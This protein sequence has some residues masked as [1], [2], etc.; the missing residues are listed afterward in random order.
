MDFTSLPVQRSWNMDFIHGALSFAVHTEEVLGFHPFL[1]FRKLTSEKE[2][3]FLK[4]FW[5]VAFQCSFSNASSQTEPGGLCSGE[6]SLENLPESVFEMSMTG[7]SYSIYNAVH[8]IAEG[9]HAMHSTSM[10]RTIRDKGWHETVYREPWQLLHYLRSISFNNNVGETISFESNGKLIA[11]FDIINWVTFPNQSFFR[12]KVGR[13][14]SQHFPGKIFTISEDTIQWPR[15]LTEGRP[16]SVCNANC[17]SGYSRTKIEGKPFCCYDCHPCPEGKISNLNDMDDC[18]P[19]PEDQYPNKEQNSCLSKTL[20]FLSYEETLGSILAICSLSSSIILL[21]VLGIFIKYKDTPIVKANNRNLT[22]ILLISLL[23]SFLCALLFIG[24]PHKMTCVLRQSAFGVIF[25]VAV[26]C[27]LAKTIVVILAFMATQPKSTMRKWVGKRLAISI[28]FFCSFIQVVLCTV[29]L[30]TFPPFPDFNMH[31]MAEEIIL[32]CNENSFVM[33]YCVLGFMFLLALVSFTVAFFARKLPD[34]F[35]EAKFIT[36]SMLIFCSVWLSFV[37]S[38]LTTRGKHM[39]AVEI[40]SIMTSSGGLLVCIF[41]PKCFIIIL[42]P[43]LNS[44]QQLR[45]RNT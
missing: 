31:L 40:F 32:E 34:S 25:T 33:F 8:A 26:S 14:E 43:E 17:R 22:Y 2:D 11:G 41:F 42:R 21:L 13:M 7:H 45:Q 18:F 30:L 16:F 20:T 37:P 38:Y 1:Q 23:L 19:C 9:L 3:G 35:N 29:W 27:V 6:E 10:K 44:K 15:N 24:K 36:F 4:D 28:V 12:V 39:V 5:E